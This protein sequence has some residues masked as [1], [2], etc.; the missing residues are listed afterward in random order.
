MGSVSALTQDTHNLS[1]GALDVV[2]I[3]AATTNRD[4]TGFTGGSTGVAVLLVN[5]GATYTIT[6]KHA[7]TS[8]AE[9]NRVLA[10]GAT[11]YA[12]TANGH[13]VLLVY[14]TSES[15]WRAI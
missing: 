6:V 5:T 4:L 9:A 3:S 1:L 14:D 12:V 15:R 7:H 10:K 11:D 13:A 2:R 8:S